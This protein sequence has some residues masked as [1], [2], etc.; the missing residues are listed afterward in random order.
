LHI[1]I[2][3]VEILTS[4]TVV[5]IPQMLFLSGNSS[6]LLWFEILKVMVNIILEWQF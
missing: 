3:L 6:K 2:L 1:A 4:V 5:F